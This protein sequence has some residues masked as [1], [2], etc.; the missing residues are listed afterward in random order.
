[1]NRK[2][3]RFGIIFGLIFLFPSPLTA[4]LDSFHYG[5]IKIAF[6]NGYVRALGTDL[7]TIKSLKKNAIDMKKYAALNVDKYME[8]VAQLNRGTNVRKNLEN[9]GRLYE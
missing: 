9:P 4:G 6:M 5:I 2:L 1:M 7:E 3:I 8:E